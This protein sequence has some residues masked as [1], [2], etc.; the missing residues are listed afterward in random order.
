MIALRRWDRRKPAAVD[1]LVL[2][3]CEEADAHDARTLEETQQRDPDCYAYVSKLLASVR[4][5]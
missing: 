3:T 5:A 1:N 4:G 2:L